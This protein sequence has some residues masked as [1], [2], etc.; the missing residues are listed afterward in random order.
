MTSLVPYQPRLSLAEVRAEAEAFLPIAMSANHSIKTIEDAVALASYSNALLV[1]VPIGLKE[2]HMIDGKPTPSVWLALGLIKR[3]KHHGGLPLLER[4]PV[5][6][7]QGAGEA[8][9]CAVWTWRRGEPDPYLGT[10]SWAEAVQAGMVGNAQ[11]RRYG[12]DMIY[13]NALFRSIRRGFSDVFMGAVYDPVAELGTNDPDIIDA[14]YTVS[15]EVKGPTNPQAELEAAWNDAW[16]RSVMVQDELITF[17]MKT[18]LASGA[19]LTDEQKIQFAGQ[20]RE[21]APIAF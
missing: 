11:W 6:E 14:D 16:D 1:P 3:A 9:Q 17:E 18:G 20:L 15:Y 5:E 12:K 7:W 2:I 8:L 13:K 10:F 19:E 21:A 4:G